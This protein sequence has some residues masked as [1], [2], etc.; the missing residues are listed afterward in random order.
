ME[1]R[2]APLKKSYM[3]IRKILA[4]SAD[5]VAGS[6]A[7]HVRAREARGEEN[8]ALRVR[9]HFIA[10]EPANPPVLQA[11][12]ILQLILITVNDPTEFSSLLMLGKIFGF[13]L[14]WMIYG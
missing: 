9:A 12:K 3:D 8:L 7:I 13:C 14:H 5:G 4:C 2:D 10:L 11:R 6:N 1:N